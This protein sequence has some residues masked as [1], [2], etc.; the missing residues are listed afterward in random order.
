MAE[1]LQ[2]QSSYI[3][4]LSHVWVNVSSMTFHYLPT[5][6]KGYKLSNAHVAKRWQFIEHKK[7]TFVGFQDAL[8]LHGGV[9]TPAKRRAHEKTW[10][11][12][13]PVVEE[14]VRSFSYC[15]TAMYYTPLQVKAL[16]WNG[17]I[18]KSLS[19]INKMFNNKSTNETGTYFLPVR[20]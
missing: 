5:L 14:V 20:F 3:K 16:H 11:V 18:S 12:C 1:H 4:S 13:C 15:N 7:P 6:I 8:H 17:L 9:L 2:P 19:N 10:N